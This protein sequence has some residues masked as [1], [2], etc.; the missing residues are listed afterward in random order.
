VASCEVYEPRQ[1]WL[2]PD[3]CS[4]FAVIVGCWAAHFRLCGEREKQ[5]ST[6]TGT[7]VRKL[8]RFKS[9]VV[10]SAQT[11]NQKRDLIRGPVRPCLP[12][13]I[14]ASSMQAKKHRALR[15]LVIISGTF[16]RAV[17]DY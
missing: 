3:S 12:T 9:M 1:C 10:Q 5:G 8:I 15:S 17:W 16:S 7:K 4:R 2:V 14:A 6:A 13:I 11:I